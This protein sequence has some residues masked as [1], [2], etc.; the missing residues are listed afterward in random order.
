MRTRISRNWNTPSRWPWVCRM[1]YGMF[2]LEAA[3]P[4]EAPPTPCSKSSRTCTSRVRAS[5]SSSRRQRETKAC[6]HDQASAGGV[7]ALLAT[8]S[9]AEI[10]STY[11]YNKTLAQS[12]TVIPES[13]QQR[14]EREERRVRAQGIFTTQLIKE[15]TKFHVQQVLAA[16]RQ[17]RG[18]A[19]W[20]TGRGSPHRGR[21]GRGDPG[22]RRGQAQR[23]PGAPAPAPAAS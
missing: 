17:Q 13:D 6:R 7:A 4:M 21:G 3:F 18:R 22:A 10:R 2:N 19:W 1:S 11:N 16:S 12:S 14:L 15:E 20:Q 23:G 5:S 8:Q 9:P